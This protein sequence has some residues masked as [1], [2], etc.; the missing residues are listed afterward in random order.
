[1][2]RARPPAPRAVRLR[3]VAELAV[4]LEPDEIRLA[5]D[6]QRA[7]LRH[8][9]AAAGLEGLHHQLQGIRAGLEALQAQRQGRGAIRIGGR[10]GQRVLEALLRLGGIGELPVLP[11][12]EL[13][14]PRRQPQRA[15]DAPAA[16]GRI[17]QRLQVDVCG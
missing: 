14:Q 6:Q 17:E 15:R 10:L 4:A 2:G 1:M 13:R 8:A 9:A 16:R 5:G 11:G 12:R 3:D 7:R